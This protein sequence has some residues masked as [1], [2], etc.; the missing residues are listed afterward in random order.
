M[1]M[2]NINK[3]CKN[4]INK[5]LKKLNILVQVGEIIVGKL[6]Y[7]QKEV[8]Q[9]IKNLR[10]D[11]NKKVILIIDFISISTLFFLFLVF[12]KINTTK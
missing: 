2:R 7:L 6:I 9:K 12:N 10:V 5:I 1:K 11:Y 8:T 3:S 4:F